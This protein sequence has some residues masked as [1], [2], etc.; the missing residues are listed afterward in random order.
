MKPV[1]QLREG[2]WGPCLQACLASILELPAGE[3]PDFAADHGHRWFRE[4]VRW[5]ER[6]HLHMVYVST[7]TMIADLH[8]NNLY[9]IAIGDSVHQHRHSIVCQ[10]NSVIHD[11]HSSR[12]GLVQLED[13]LIVIPQWADQHT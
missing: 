7:T 8:P 9:W 2:L 10:S 3:V 12:A 5:G 1:D 4:L 13:A 11:P 6:K